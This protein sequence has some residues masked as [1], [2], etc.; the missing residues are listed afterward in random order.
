MKQTILPNVL[1]GVNRKAWE[2]RGRPI[3]SDRAGTRYQWIVPASR[4]EIPPLPLALQR[5]QGKHPEAAWRLVE[6]AM[7]AESISERPAAIWEATAWLTNLPDVDDV[8]ARAALLDLAMRTFRLSCRASAGRPISSGSFVS[9]SLDC[10]VRIDNRLRV[11]DLA[12]YN[13]T[14][15]APTGALLRRRAFRGA[16]RI[17]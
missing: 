8:T 1:T 7:Q 6:A 10:D 13:R 2:A 14:E 15:S 16:R 12:C 17:L 3:L 11:F 5:I 9:G 4:F